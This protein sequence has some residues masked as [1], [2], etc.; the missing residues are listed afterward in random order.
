MFGAT[1][2][3]FELVRNRIHRHGNT[4]DDRFAAESVNGKAVPGWISLEAGA[5]A[6]KTLELHRKNALAMPNRIE[7]LAP[8]GDETCLEAAL[9]AGA[10]AIYFGL[11]VGFNARARARNIA[12]DRLSEVMHRVHDF[13]R[14]GYLTLNTVVFDDELGS[15]ERAIEAA[16]E[17]GV[18]A[19]IVQDIGLFRL[20]KQLV[21]S[22]RIHASTQTTCTD[23]AAVRWLAKLGAERIT[24]GRELSMREIAA[25][26]AESPIELEVFAHGALCI[27]YSGQCLTS[28]AIGGRSANRGACA[29]ACRLPYD[30][31]VDGMPR[32]LG[33]IAYLLSPRDL[34]ASQFV[35]DLV[36]TGV[37]AL[38]IE[39]RMKGPQYVAAT[40][41]LYRMIADAAATPTDRPRTGDTPPCP[42]AVIDGL[43]EQS[44]QA[45]SR[46]SS[47][48][49][50]R[51]VD[52]QTLVPGDTCD[53]VGIEVGNCRGVLSSGGKQ[54]LHLQVNRRL[55]R[56][57]GIL[58]QGGRAGQG[59]LGGRIWQMRVPD[60]KTSQRPEPK[61]TP[62]ASSDVARVDAAE[63]LFVWLGPDQSIAGTYAARR[64]FR[65]SDGSEK[66]DL[67]A[68]VSRE[69]ERVEVTAQLTGRFGERPHLHLKTA[70]GRTADVELDVAL[71][72]AKKHAL[73]HATVVE[74]LERLGDTAYR[75]SG[76][77]LEI[78]DGAMLPISAL[79]RAR[80]VATDQLSLAARRRHGVERS[81]GAGLERLQ[82][83]TPPPGGLYVTCRTRE[84]AEGALAAGAQGVYLDFLALTG[85]GPLL[86]ELRQSHCATLGVAL[87]RIRKL[88]EQKIDSY[89]TA[90]EPDAVLIRS[91]GS[92]ADRRGSHTE[93]ACGASEPSTRCAQPQW[94]GDFSLNA[95]NHWTASELLAQPLTA[96]TP[97]YDLDAKQLLAL[98]DTPLAPFAEV[99]IH[100]PMPLFHMEH[101]VFAALLSNG[102]DHRDCGRP[103]ERHVVSLR[104]RT[105]ID[106]PLEADVNCRNTVFHGIAQSAADV[107]LPL[108]SKGVRRFRIELVRETRAQTESLVRTHLGLMAGRT[109]PIDVRREAAANG[110][111]V[112]RGSLRVVG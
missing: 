85:V 6:K 9:R 78:P 11:D 58:V 88:G 20:I 48:G 54:W 19:L 39:G 73:D 50:L 79:N 66:A 107:V 4:L 104:D 91:L 52:H 72:P 96:F 31:I 7:V 65:T 87:P 108:M 41:R 75:L 23:L 8:A 17:A 44:L 30:L 82:Q 16:A 69:P 12:L 32:D 64:V 22:L 35:P 60:Q 67:D 2:R 63:D 59:E 43:R 14:R 102:R 34:D 89:V 110:L 3:R 62:Q 83:R 97:G 5:I 15:A 49:F 42:S 45:F 100:H 71:E 111:R 81:H 80:R 109:T 27:A 25:L 47:S 84:Q 57:D 38:K 40:T 112:A 86:R 21:P 33:D 77:T 10:D 13:G 56:G 76:L 55:A 51:G 99:V 36:A 46:G 24:L 92:L 94:V 106:L 103:C 93:D 53:H 70:D 90:L 98:M 18:D 105:S 26:T 101:C 37:R 68:V 29:Q 95:T 28:E 74:K 61:F 1:A